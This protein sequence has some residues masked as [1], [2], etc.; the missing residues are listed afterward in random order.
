MERKK[1][2]FVILFSLFTL[3]VAGQSNKSIYSAYASGNMYKWKYSMDSLAAKPAK[4]NKENLDLVNFQYGYIAWCIGKK[5]KS[6]A[7]FV[8]NKSKTIVELLEKQKYNLSMLYAYKAAFVGFEI[9]ISPYKAPFLGSQSSD[10]AN[11]SI[12]LN[13]K[14]A[15]AHAQLGNIALHTPKIFGGSKSEAVQHYIKAL[16]LMQADSKNIEDNW[17]Y[18]NLLASIINTY[19]ELEQFKSAKTYS[20]KTLTI[21]P[22]FD[23]VKNKL[24]PEIL[25]NL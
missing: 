14:N 23:W 6:E 4:T 11:Q 12:A 19:M 9:G 10:Y 2:L 5:K 7:E 1:Y 22:E 20:E 18:L 25:K 13:P 8:M 3:V 15:F 16:I 24:Y 17:N 21:E